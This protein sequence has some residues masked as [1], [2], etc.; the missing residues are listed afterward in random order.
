MAA[1]V[2]GLAGAILV[3]SGRAS[4]ER[5]AETATSEVSRAAVQ[6]G[7]RLDAAIASAKMRASAL[8]AMPVVRAAVETDQATL[9]D[10]ARSEFVF[11]PAKDETIEVF[12][13]AAEGRPS[14]L[15]RLPPRAPPLHLDAREV[16]AE[17]DDALR[18]TVRAP[19]APLYG[20][21]TLHGELALGER[22]DLGTLRARLVALGVD[23]TLTGL[24]DPVRLAGANLPPAGTFGAELPGPPGA[25]G[26]LRIR[27]RLT[28]VP[29]GLTRVRAGQALL[30]LGLLLTAA[31]LICRSDL[32]LRRRRPPLPIHRSAV[33]LLA[34]Q[35]TALAWSDENPPLP[36]L[37]PSSPSTSGDRARAG[38]EPG[39]L[40]AGKFRVFQRLGAGEMADVYLAQLPDSSKV[41]ALK[42]LRRELST[43]LNAREFLAGPRA[44]AALAHPNLVRI[45]D[46]GETEGA[47]FV[48]MEYVEGCSLHALLRDLRLNHE[49]M[50]LRPSLKLA[51]GVC[52]GLAV[53]HAA[54][55]VHRDVKPSNVLVGRHG[56]IKLTDLAGPSPLGHGSDYQAPEQVLGEPV[57]PA[58]DVYAVGAILHELLTGGRIPLNRG[59]VQRLGRRAWPLLPKPSSLRPEL[60]R[61]L[62]EILARALHFQPRRRHA[63][64][65]DLA[66]DLERLLMDGD[67][68]PAGVLG[69]WV[70]RARHSN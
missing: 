28:R 65:H 34:A 67:T 41:V 69:D 31:F 50:P 9:K 7:T 35:P 14:S 27:A 64:A 4:A 66:L 22:V 11:Q 38:D 43:A 52:E 61:E 70:E 19:V 29:H 60:P 44:A 18:V 36:Q 48:A 58:A 37:V 8:A 25:N 10:L 57:D 13:V 12:Q 46:L 51:I 53:A 24:E 45:L 30:G 26:P 55:L 47:V 23:A 68:P 49:L 16:E 20:G 17:D 59:E 62:D 42:V 63:S 32:P 6:L 40:V 39:D 1:L 54:G 56:A 15:L 33:Q 2:A 5:A 21:S 3:A